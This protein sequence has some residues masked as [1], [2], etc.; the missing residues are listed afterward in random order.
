MGFS[1]GGLGGLSSSSL[2]PLGSFFENEQAK[3]SRWKQ[4]S[5]IQVV[6][7]SGLVCYHFH[8]FVTSLSGQHLS[9]CPFST[10][11]E[12]AYPLSKDSLWAILQFP[13]L[14]PASFVWSSL[15]W[16]STTGLVFWARHDALGLSKLARLGRLWRRVAGWDRVEATGHGILGYLNFHD[17]FLLRGVIVGHG[18]FAGFSNN[19]KET[20]PKWDLFPVLGGPWSHFHQ[21]A[22]KQ[23]SRGSRRNTVVFRSAVLW[24]ASGRSSH[25]MSWEIR[26]WV[27]RE[28]CTETAGLVVESDESSRK[29]AI[30]G[31]DGTHQGSAWSPC[32]VTVQSWLHVPM[33]SSPLQQQGAAQAD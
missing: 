32:P 29:C 31:D 17:P 8:E 9:S 13:L 22:P 3:K 1:V 23:W 26:T 25:Y 7:S 15:F 19:V 12:S 16:G 28:A 6:H 30:I 10:T 20:L 14:L 21:R 11:I 18:V 33:V 24:P 27:S 2:L 4:R 5:C